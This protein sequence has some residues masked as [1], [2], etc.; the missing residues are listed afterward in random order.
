MWKLDIP[1]MSQ[2]EK[3]DVDMDD[4]IKYMICVGPNLLSEHMCMILWAKTKKASV[5]GVHKTHTISNS[6]KIVQSKG[7]EWLD[8]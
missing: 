7:D 6:V 1:D 2:R 4:R 8:W 3:I 5:F